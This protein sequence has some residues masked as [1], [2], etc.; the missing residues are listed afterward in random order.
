M[1][2]LLRSLAIVLCVVIVVV[3]TVRVAFRAPGISR[4]RPHRR[5][6]HHLVQDG[7]QR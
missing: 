7:A 5:W 1:N 6:Q 4:G 3:L 2:R